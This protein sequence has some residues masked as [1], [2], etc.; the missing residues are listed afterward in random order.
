MQGQN[1]DKFTRDM[2]DFDLSSEESESDKAC[3]ETPLKKQSLLMKNQKTL[4][5]RQNSN[6]SSM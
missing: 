6:L 2:Y 1:S 4:V 5:S 3:T